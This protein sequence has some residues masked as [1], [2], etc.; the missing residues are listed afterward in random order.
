M[1]LFK[2][3]TPGFILSVQQYFLIIIILTIITGC[4]SDKKIPNVSNIKFDITTERFEKDFF[5]NGYN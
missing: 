5:F 3:V 2:K 1:I 4:N